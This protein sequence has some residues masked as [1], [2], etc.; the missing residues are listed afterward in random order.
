MAFKSVFHWSGG[1]DCTLALYQL[2]QDREY[3][4]SKLLTSV[5]TSHGRVSMHGVRTA[6]LEE[7]ARNIGI[8]L[9]LMQLPEQ[10]S[11]QVY[12]QL[13][14]SAMAGL[15]S[16]GFT[17]AIY[18]DIFLEDLRAYRE[19]QLAAQGFTAHFP[20]WKRNTT[21]LLQEFL[22]LGFKTIV[23]CAQ[24]S[25]LG[26]SFAGRIIDQG[27]IRDLPKGVDPCGENGEFHTF[28][29]DGPIFKN[30]VHFS[31][32]EQVYRSYAAPKSADN[33]DKAPAEDQMGFWFC[34]LLPK[35]AAI[36]QVP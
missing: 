18:G 11:M 29:F 22:D 27:F 26:K 36:D 23:V 19:Q 31:I 21:D 5:N 33:P 8:P 24:A 20:L 9:Q 7:Q 15:K 12:N 13:M 25:K 16:E 2:L 10:P 17:Y 1:K 30:P 6:L 34:D 4:V 3:T 14:E 32:G 28:V 35:A